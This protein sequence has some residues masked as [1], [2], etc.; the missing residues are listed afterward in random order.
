M[1]TYRRARGPGG[2]VL[3]FLGLAA[4]GCGGDKP[5]GSVAGTVKYN[6][7]PVTMGDVNFV[8]KTGAAAMAKIDEAG[9][10]K[11]DGKLEAGE[12]KVYVTPPSPEPPVPGVAPP[13][14]PPFPVPAKYRDATTSGVTVTVKPGRN[15]DL[16]IVLN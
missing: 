4:A 13:P 6:G 10:Y 14:L 16:P 5:A 9:G 12:Y 11:V 3:A 7:S 8:S 1:A 2:L 15:D